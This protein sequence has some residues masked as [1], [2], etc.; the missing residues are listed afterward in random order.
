MIRVK[1]IYGIGMVEK[2]TQRR[3]LHPFK[4]FRAEKILYMLLVPT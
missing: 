2:A 1:G 3:A 4:K